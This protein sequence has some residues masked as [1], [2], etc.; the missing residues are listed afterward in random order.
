MAIIPALIPVIKE[1]TLDVAAASVEFTVPSGYEILFL[2]WHDVYGSS[3]G[4]VEFQVTFNGDTGNNYDWAEN[5]FG[6]ASSTTN[7]AANM[8]LAVNMIGDTDGLQRHANGTV[9]IFNR[10]AQEKVMI[11]TPVRFDKAGASDED[12][13]GQH[14][15]SK[16]RNT[17]DEIST[18]TLTASGGNITAGSQF[19]LRG[20]RTN[21]APALGSKDICQF[22]GSADFAAAGVTL[23]TFPPGYGMLWLFW[24]DVQGDHN[25][26]Q[27]LTMT[28]AGGNGEYDHSLQAFGTASST[29]NAA[30]V[31]NIGLIADDDGEDRASSGFACI[32]NRLAQEKVIIGTSIYAEGG[33]EDVHGY[34]LEAKDRTTDEEVSTITIAPAAGNLD[35]GKF[36]LIG[37]KVP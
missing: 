37:V 11:G 33:D 3:T 26:A 21:K 36:W 6:A 16:W 1:V 20:L 30:N 7:G 27:F 14:N 31:I 24:H 35:A 32:F 15:S 10:A 29:S 28:M 5:A 13:V 9:V 19:I 23:P 22:I 18:I 4:N 2:E 8:L 12:L 34:H 25:D 17:S